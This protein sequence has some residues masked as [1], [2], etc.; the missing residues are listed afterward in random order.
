MEY[1]VKPIGFVKNLRKSIEDDFWGKITSEIQIIDELPES[2]LDGIEDFSHLEIIYLFHK[3]KTEDIVLSSSNP[4]DNGKWPKTGIFAQ[5]KK[6]RPN[7][8]GLTIVK[9]EEKNNKLL[10][11]LGLDAIDGTPVLDIKPVMKEFMPK[12]EIRQPKWVEEM[13]KNYW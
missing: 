1:T 11:V 2:V 5:R 12:E 3:V 10:T 13:M 8:L 6:E 9:L 4:R 7:R